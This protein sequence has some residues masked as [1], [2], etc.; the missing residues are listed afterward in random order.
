MRELYTKR[1]S[2]GPTT[3]DALNATPVS[4]IGNTMLKGIPDDN[5]SR[6]VPSQQHKLQRSNID[7]KPGECCKGGKSAPGSATVKTD[8]VDLPVYLSEPGRPTEPFSLNPSLALAPLL[9]VLIAQHSTLSE[10]T[11]YDGAG[12]TPEEGRRTKP[13]LVPCGFHGG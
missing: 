6:S 2:E 4:R 5:L 1:V 8:A 11:R 10:T 12:Q 13:V 9:K 7:G 3:L